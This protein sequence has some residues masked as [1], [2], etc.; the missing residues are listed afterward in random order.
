MALRHF[1]GRPNIHATWHLAP[2][3]HNLIS[4]VGPTLA[5]SAMQK[6]FHHLHCCSCCTR[7]LG[8]LAAASVCFAVSADRAGQADACNSV[9]V[10][11]ACTHSY[12]DLQDSTYLS[13][14]HLQMQS[15]SMHVA[16]LRTA[17]SCADSAD[18][19]L[20]QT[21]WQGIGMTVLFPVHI[22]LHSHSAWPGYISQ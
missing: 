2:A 17:C 11:E 22:I 10:R 5:E 9:P 18:V 6:Q 20:K 19:A 8:F 4:S 21:A 12:I 7:D 13:D 15:H 1:L 16:L 3:S 14:A